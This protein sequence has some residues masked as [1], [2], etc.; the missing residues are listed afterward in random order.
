MVCGGVG[1]TTA[2]IPWLRIDKQLSSCTA[3]RTRPSALSGAARRL[4]RKHRIRF[5]IQSPE[6]FL[7]ESNLDSRHFSTGSRPRPGAASRWI[8]PAFRCSGQGTPLPL[9]PPPVPAAWLVSCDCRLR[10]AVLIVFAG[11][12]NNIHTVSICGRFNFTIAYFSYGFSVFLCGIGALFGRGRQLQLVD[13]SVGFA[14]PNN[15]LRRL[16]IYRSI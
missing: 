12:L 3:V 7:H 5:A 9:Q 15:R 6:L 4:A 16:Y 1:P 10:A 11:N 13:S 2:G 8:R 14:W